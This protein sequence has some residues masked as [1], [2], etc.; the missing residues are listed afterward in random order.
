M[1]VLFS[2][3]SFSYCILD[4]DK[5]SSHIL[6]KEYILLLVICWH[7]R[8]V[9][10]SLDVLLNMFFSPFTLGSHSPLSLLYACMIS[11]LTLI[12]PMGAMYVCLL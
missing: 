8:L 7:Y 11:P 5:E 12:Y 6:A 2:H 9:S 1:S 10:L 3:E 4:T